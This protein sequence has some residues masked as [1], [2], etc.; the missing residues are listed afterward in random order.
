MPKAILSI[1]CL[2]LLFT[3]CTSDPIQ[4]VQEGSKSVEAFP[5]TQVRLLE[6]PFQHA[7]EL[8]IRSLLQYDPDRL[9]AKF[10]IEAGLEPKAK[11]YEGWEA[12]TIAGHSL[13]HHLSACA[14]MYQ[15]TNDSRFLE[16]VNYIVDELEAVQNAHGDGY[17]GAFAN[18]KKIF[19][20][21][22]ARGN[23]RS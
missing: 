4:G 22:V 9:L 12:E 1:C 10:R 21:E 18:G 7:T 3:A 17:L 20:E 6:G 11:P 15:S 19:E 8:N 23:I 5:L 14:L 2:L 13:G 16:R